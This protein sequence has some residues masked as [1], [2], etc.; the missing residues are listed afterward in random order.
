MAYFIDFA[1]DLGRTTISMHRENISSW[2]KDSSSAGSCI[3]YSAYL[4]TRRWYIIWYLSFGKK[5]KVLS[6]DIKDSWREREAGHARQ[7][8]LLQTHAHSLDEQWQLCVFNTDAAQ[9]GGLVPR[10]IIRSGPTLF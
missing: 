7:E 8:T 3:G 10:P 6:S 5:K 4:S 9:H 2:R 1:R